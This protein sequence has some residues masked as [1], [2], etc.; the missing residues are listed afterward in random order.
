MWLS[1][2]IARWKLFADGPK[3][4]GTARFLK[5]SADESLRVSNEIDHGPLERVTKPSHQP[6]S[7]RQ[8]RVHILKTSNPEV[9]R[10]VQFPVC[11]PT[12]NNAKNS[13]R[14]AWR[15]RLAGIKSSSLTGTFR[16]NSARNTRACSM[17]HIWSE[18]P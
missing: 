2:Q 4:S 9:I 18:F 12:A 15:G 17:L 16:R 7:V 6:A 1:T 11:R 8:R 10:Q 13:F 14:R 5:Y 3:H